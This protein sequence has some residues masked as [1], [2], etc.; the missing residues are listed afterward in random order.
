MAKTNKQ[1]KT[2]QQTKKSYQKNSNNS[3][4]QPLFEVTV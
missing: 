4:L 3:N 1:K 2:K